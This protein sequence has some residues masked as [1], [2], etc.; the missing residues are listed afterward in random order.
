LKHKQGLLGRKE[1]KYH[2]KK[3]ILNMY[4]VEND[5]EWTGWRQDIS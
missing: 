2:C 3:K 1:G 4:N 5:W